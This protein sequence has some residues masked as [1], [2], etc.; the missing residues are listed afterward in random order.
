MH[1]TREPRGTIMPC[2]SG[3]TVGETYV[4]LIPK[5]VTAGLRPI[6]RA[7]PPDGRHG[8]TGRRSGPTGPTLPDDEQFGI[9][10]MVLMYGY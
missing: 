9:R 8:D 7:V 4:I 5:D 3:C 2:R 1:I 6:R 10:I